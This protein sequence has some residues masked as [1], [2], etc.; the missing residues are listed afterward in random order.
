MEEIDYNPA[1]G[2]TVVVE[3]EK[4]IKVQVKAVLTDD[5]EFDGAGL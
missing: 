1:Y 4:T 2:S 5:V 3:E